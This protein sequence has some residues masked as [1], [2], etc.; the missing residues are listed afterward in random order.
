MDMVIHQTE[1]D[2]LDLVVQSQTTKA[3]SN[4]VDSGNEFF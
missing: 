1:T 4:P 2:Y 3:E